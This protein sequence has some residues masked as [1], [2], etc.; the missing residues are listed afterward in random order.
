[1]GEYKDGMYEIAK[2]NI[3]NPVITIESEGEEMVF[4]GNNARIF[5]I[6]VLVGLR[7]KEDQLDIDIKL[8]IN[9]T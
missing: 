8:N 5:A 7:D 1:M 2:G 4:K 9:G 6:G 3:E